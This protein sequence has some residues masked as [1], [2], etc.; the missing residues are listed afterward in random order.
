MLKKAR[1]SFFSYLQ[2]KFIKDMNMNR[3]FLD[4]LLKQRGFWFTLALFGA[5]VLL[6]QEQLSKGF[7]I[8]TFTFTVVRVYA[9]SFIV[10]AISMLLFDYL[11][12][13]K[14]NEENEFT[15]RNIYMNE[16]LRHEI[17][18]LREEMVLIKDPDYKNGRDK[19]VTLTEPDKEKLFDI[20]TKSVSAN[21][22]NEFLK[23]LDEKYSLKAVDEARYKELLQNFEQTRAR[24]MR[25]IDGLSRRAN[26]NLVIGTITTI[27]AV[28]VLFTTVYDKVISMTDPA[29]TLAYF[30]PKVSTVIFIEIFS[31]FFL[32]LY[33]SNL[34]DVK[35]YQNEMTN[36]EFKILSLKS[37]LIT[38]DKDT[39]KQIILELSKIERNFILQKGETTVEIETAKN[40]NKFDKSF[41]DNLKSFTES[42]G[43]LRS[44]E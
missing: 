16:E 19:I 44:R 42:L 20:I 37:A 36:I 17:M 1:G 33:R 13:D 22:N 14:R 3:R 4:I 28:G 39:S 2:I 11:R 31:F 7:E 27:I 8:S 26:L 34:G 5:I 25:E 40:Q 23:S 15:R 24:V 18:Q 43:R 6:F 35:Y 12:G 10:I 30:I 9:F 41:T 38:N 29:A 32:K 21:I